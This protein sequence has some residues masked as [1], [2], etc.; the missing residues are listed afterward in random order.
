MSYYRDGGHRWLRCE[1]PKLVTIGWMN[2]PHPVPQ[3]TVDPEDVARLEQIIMHGWTPVEIEGTYAC[4]FCFDDPDTEPPRRIVA[5]EDTYIG[6]RNICVPG[7]ACI[8]IFPDQI[9]HYIDTHG[10]KPPDK[11]LRA[12]RKVDPKDPAYEKRCDELWALVDERHSPSK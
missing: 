11:F 4:S 7:R 3:G 6:W 5:G 2:K 9:L 12:M 8:Y 10:Y 1:H